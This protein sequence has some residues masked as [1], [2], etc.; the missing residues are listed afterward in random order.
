[1]SLLS[2][3][4]APS[5]T[6]FGGCNWIRTNALFTELVYSQLPSTSRPHTLLFYLAPHSGNDPDY[7]LVNSQ[8]HVHTR[9]L[10]NIILMA[11]DVGFEPTLWESKSHAL[12]QLGESPTIFC[13]APTMNRTQDKRFTKPLLY[14][15]SYKGYLFYGTPPQT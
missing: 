13:G 1:M 6:N 7:T 9:V 10:R 2:Y 3:R 15:L 11:E 14:Q 4:A 8:A 5:R 12:D